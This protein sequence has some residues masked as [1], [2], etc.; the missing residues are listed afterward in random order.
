MKRLQGYRENGVEKP[1]QTTRG[2]RLYPHFKE[3]LAGALYLYMNLTCSM[4]AITSVSLSLE[5]A[6]R[7]AYETVGWAVI[8][9]L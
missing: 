1:R 6:T 4:R 7:S 3:H 9:C 5:E 2:L 8:L